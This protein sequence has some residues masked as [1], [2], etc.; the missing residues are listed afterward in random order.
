MNFVGLLPL[1]YCQKT[2]L[3]STTRHYSAYFRNIQVLTPVARQDLNYRF[4]SAAQTGFYTHDVE[5]RELNTHIYDIIY[6]GKVSMRLIASG[7]KY[8]YDGYIYDGNLAET[9]S[10]ILYN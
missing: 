8:S 3:V 1:L 7:Y 10:S 6:D 2:S 4:I 9:A 5:A